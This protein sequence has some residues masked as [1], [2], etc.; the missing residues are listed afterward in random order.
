MKINRNRKYIFKL[1][2]QQSF[3]ICVTKFIYLV[4]YKLCMKTYFSFSLS[5]SLSLSLCLFSF[6]SSSFTLSFLSFSL[7]TSFWVLPFNL[8]RFYLLLCPLSLILFLYF[9]FV[10]LKSLFPSLT[11]SFS[12]SLPDSL[13]L[14]RFN[15]KYLMYEIE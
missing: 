9:H 6:L 8:F 3:L 11:L 14:P 2:R 13:F 15:M 12:L 7:F 1:Q 4:Y 5:H 10:Q